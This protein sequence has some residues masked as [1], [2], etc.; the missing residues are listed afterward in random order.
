MLYLSDN[1]IIKLENST[2][3]DMDKLI[4]LDLSIN[5][6]SK[7]PPVIF[8]LPSLKRLYLSQNQNINIVET[9]EEA[10]PITSPLESLDIGF[11]DLETLPNLGIMPYLLLYN[12]SGNNL[13]NMEIKDVAGLCNLKT[14][15]N[16]N[17]TT[18]FTNPCDCWNIQ[19]WLKEKKVK[20]ME[21]LCEVQ[22][23][24]KCEQ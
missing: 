7:L 3:Q 24:G 21:M 23:Q 9:V 8:H 20:F 22:T 4:S 16:D 1:M 11:N 12:I 17:F 2:F 14:L 18:Y 15:V 19:R 13:D 6:L 10:S 5:G